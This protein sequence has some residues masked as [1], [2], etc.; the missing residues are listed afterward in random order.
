ML[1]AQLERN[2]RRVHGKDRKQRKEPVARRKVLKEGSSNRVRS[3]AGK[4][5][6]YISSRKGERGRGVGIGYGT[7]HKC[8][9]RNKRAVELV[10]YAVYS[11][12][13]QE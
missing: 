1:T 12:H 2:E 5:A 3:G 6:L 4:C 10:K 8:V 11:M 7:K 9:V 13:M